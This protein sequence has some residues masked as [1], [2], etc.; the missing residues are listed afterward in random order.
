M[1]PGE[2][3]RN[4]RVKIQSLMGLGAPRGSRQKSIFSDGSDVAEWLSSPPPEALPAIS[5]PQPSN[6]AQT[7]NGSNDTSADDVFPPVFEPIVVPPSTFEV[8][9]VLDNREIRAKHDRDYIQEELTRK[10]VRPIMKSLEAGDALWI[11]K[12]RRDDGDERP[13]DE[14]GEIVLDWIVERKRLD[15]LVGSIK[16]GRFREQKVLLVLTLS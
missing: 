6:S 7:Q 4:T 15:D 13:A 16:D 9:L 12:R 1:E 14:T 8:H 10:G 11:A 2:Y 3:V 5:D